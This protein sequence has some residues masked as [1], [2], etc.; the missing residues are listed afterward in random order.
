MNSQ[1][2]SPISDRIRFN[3]LGKDNHGHSG[4]GLWFSIVIG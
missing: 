3:P 2:A 4:I 1:K